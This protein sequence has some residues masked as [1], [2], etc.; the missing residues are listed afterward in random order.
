MIRPTKYL[1]LKTCVLRISAIILAELH[2]SHV[3]RLDELDVV[4]RREAGDNARFNFIPAL[5]FLFLLGE[6]EYDPDADAIFLMY[7]R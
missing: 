6:I 3:K 2:Q 5:N 7:R 4:I 1:D